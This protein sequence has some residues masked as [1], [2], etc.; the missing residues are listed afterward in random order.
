MDRHGKQLVALVAMLLCFGSAACG[1][2][3][4]VPDRA[5][6]AW[7]QSALQQLPETSSQVLLVTGDD[8]AGPEATLYA[9][10]K[11]R[12]AWNLAFPPMPAMV[13]WKGFA[14]P[15]A[16]REGDRRTP[17][18]V[19]ALR[20][21]FGYAPQIDS[22]MP[23]RQ[24]GPE[25]IWVDAPASSDYNRWMRKEETNAASF[26]VMH[27]TDH[28]YKYGIVIEYN[29]GP[30]VKGAGSAIFIHVRGGENVPTTGC[31]A[32]SE[33]DL[34]TI[35]RWLDPA[36]GPLAVLGT[37]DALPLQAVDIRFRPDRWTGGWGR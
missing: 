6:S 33:T 11:R 2:S 20:R 13:G 17:S 36:A 3:V 24:A 10:E 18:G 32:L 26:E 23:Y 5:A 16:K 22:N 34:L 27:R 21:A 8:A 35:L 4:V 1:R 7:V 30:I 31:V 28:R 12:H 19:F 15:G 29:T 37:R 14:P 25:D 9:L